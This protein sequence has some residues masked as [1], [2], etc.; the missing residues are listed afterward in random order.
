[1]PTYMKT[2]RC[3]MANETKM[4][5]E[6]FSHM[7][8]CLHSCL[9]VL[10]YKHNCNIKREAWLDLSIAGRLL[11]LLQIKI[12]CL[13]FIRYFSDVIYFIHTIEIFFTMII[14]DFPH[15][16]VKFKRSDL[17]KFKCQLGKFWTTPFFTNA[18]KQMIKETINV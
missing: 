10:V 4:A 3:K 14:L 5:I 1:M 12:Y 15:L 6:T 16:F 18:S 13:T 9:S 8:K 2:H 17:S 11:L 7:N